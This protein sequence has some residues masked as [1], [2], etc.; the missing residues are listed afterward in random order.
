MKK[1]KLLNAHLSHTIA[2]L[3]HGQ[4]LAIGD[5]GLPIHHDTPRIDLALTHGIPSFLDTFDVVVSEMQVEEVIVADEM[6]QVSPEL[7]A[8]LKD[9][10][11]RLEDAQ[12]KSIMWTS[13][14]HSQF[15]TLSD[16][17][18]AVVRTGECTPYANV[19]LK[20]GVVF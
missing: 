2:T 14:S 8:Q 10:I 11:S 7:F 15:K 4:T 16:Q 5:C 9:R 20:S 6:E 19:I 18:E 17:S 3:G 12:G 13:V 1:S